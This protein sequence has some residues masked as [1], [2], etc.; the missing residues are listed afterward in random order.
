[1]KLA[2]ATIP[3]TNKQTKRATAQISNV[4]IEVLDEYR[5]SIAYA[6][7][8]GRSFG[9][10]DSASGSCSCLSLKAMMP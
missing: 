7:V 3:K 1:M 6:G 8:S 2:R 5:L 10:I 9:A 4:L